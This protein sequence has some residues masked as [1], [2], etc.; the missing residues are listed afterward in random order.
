MNGYIRC[1]DDIRAI[2]SEREGSAIS[3]AEVWPFLRVLHVLS[4]DLNSS[5]RQ[6]EAS[7]RT[8]LAHTA[9]EPDPVGAAEATWNAL[10]REVGEGMPGARSFS[11]SK[12]CQRSEG[13]R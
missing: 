6:S 7:I 11:S 2:I 1:C 9:G 8:L 10:L 4:L 12:V 3:A 13:L 5:T